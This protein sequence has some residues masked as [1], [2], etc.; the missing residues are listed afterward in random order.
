MMGVAYHTKFW[1][2]IYMF[3]NLYCML[4]TLC[5][6]LETIENAHTKSLRSTVKGFFS[7]EEK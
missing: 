3:I 4:I 1:I 6:T 5:V 2:H 7:K